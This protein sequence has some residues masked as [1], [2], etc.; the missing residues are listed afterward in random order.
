ML[1]VNMHEAKSQLSRLG[2]LAWEGEEVVIAKAG[3]PYLRL[4]PYRDRLEERQLGG[5]EGKI[6]MSPD[7]D[8]PDEELMDLVENAK[9]FPDKR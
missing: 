2:K 4:E 3:E 5:L 1:K 7:F 8:D 6:W 9:I